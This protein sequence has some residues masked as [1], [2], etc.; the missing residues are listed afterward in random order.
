M[1]NVVIIH[2]SYSSNTEPWIIS[3]SDE[4]KVRGMNVYVPKF[5][6]PI[7]QDYISW[8]VLFDSYAQYIDT[9]TILVGC[10]VG[11]A[12]LL[13]Y[14]SEH[15]ISVYKTI[16]VAPFVTP[17]SNPSEQ[18]LAQTFMLP[19]FDT[20]LLKP[21][22]GRVEVVV[23]DNDLL[24]DFDISKRVADMF[25]AAITKLSGKGHF[26]S[27]N[28][29]RLLPELVELITAPVPV[30]MPEPTPVA[31]VMSESYS[32]MLPTATSALNVPVQNNPPTI[33][34]IAGQ[35]TPTAT[36]DVVALQKLLAELAAKGV[37]I[38]SSTVT[39][40]VKTTPVTPPISV[41]AQ[42]LS[43]MNTVAPAMVGTL[44]TPG[45]HVV[46]PIVGEVESI[47]FDDIHSKPATVAHSL[48][49]D[50]STSLINANAKEVSKTLN[51]Y[52]KGK[53]YSAQ[54]KVMRVF[55]VIA[56]IIGLVMLL[57]AGYF[58]YRVYFF[59]ET[60]PTIA[61]IDV[62]PLD[63][64]S[65][66]RV[67]FKR[68]VTTPEA[69]SILSEGM[70]QFDLANE[71]DIGVLRL[72][73][74]EESKISSDAA[75][76][77][78]GGT[79]PSS[80]YSKLGSFYA[81][82]ATK[83]PVTT[84]PF[85]V[86]ALDKPEPEVITELTT[87]E[88]WMA[89]DLLPLFAAGSGITLETHSVRF[90]D[91]TVGNRDIRVLVAE[92][93]PAPKVVEAPPV[94][95]VNTVITSSGIPDTTTTVVSLETTLSAG[96]IAE[97][98]TSKL[99]IASS[100]PDTLSQSITA[101]TQ[102]GATTES[103]TQEKNII[104]MFKISADEQTAIKRTKDSLTI[105]S[106]SPIFNKALLPGDILALE[107]SDKEEVDDINTTDR[108][109]STNVAPILGGAPTIVQII[110]ILQKGATTVLSYK[111][112]SLSEATVLQGQE[113]FSNLL[114]NGAS[115]LAPEVVVVE[116]G[117]IDVFGY[118]VINGKVLVFSSDID[119]IPLLADRYFAQKKSILDMFQ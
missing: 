37:A 11:A 47:S 68:N 67:T 59:N 94:D 17:I 46:A 36:T 55:R 33:T 45:A 60:L 98:A 79:T 86:F 93:K 104:E 85:A 27:V 69:V 8:K 51:D 118:S 9:E 42:S 113:V 19:A 48:V 4:L 74:E 102:V 107:S 14:L 23:S 115:V 100:G 6:T 25:G 80:I 95:S 110:D 63:A 92:R 73:D 10:G 30:S 61:D 77:M 41:Q 109:L 57:G 87:W 28:G 34:S 40:V 7:G 5:P 20:T 103:P 62:P 76:K 82:G 32:T 49:S 22:M 117:P 16:L 75:I 97:S 88:D 12:F 44:A 71:N 39:P 99:E 58:A 116:Y 3:V 72:Y 101:D 26:R 21:R 35:V 29:V 43:Q 83:N 56:V 96:E 64:V 112:L 54:E 89:R 13:R 78:I 65:I 24:V 90:Q 31:P 91:R 111:P 106:N 66:E 108:E 15:M 81:I 52:R 18:L 70:S 50:F 119:S 38:P 2:D 105:S 53:E 84:S 114:P 1:R